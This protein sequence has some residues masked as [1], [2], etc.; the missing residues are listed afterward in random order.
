MGTNSEPPAHIP[1]GLPHRGIILTIGYIRGTRRFLSCCPAGLAGEAR[2]ESNTCRRLGSRGYSLHCPLRRPQGIAKS[3]ATFRAPRAC[4]AVG[5]DR[6]L[7]AAFG[8]SIPASALP[9]CDRGVYGPRR[10]WSLASSGQAEPPVRAPTNPG[11]HRQV[12]LRVILPSL[13]C[14]RMIRLQSAPPRGSPP[15]P[16]RQTSSHS[17]RLSGA[18]HL[19][20]PSSYR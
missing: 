17:L 12:R 1:L 13:F 14:L 18:Q 10:A 5:V 19:A 15:C 9:D 7:P 6:Y 20:S 11:Q 4:F 8:P 16:R 3:P 2:D